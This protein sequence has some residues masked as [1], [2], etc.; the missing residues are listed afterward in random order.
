[1]IT[2]VLL[3]TT[4]SGFVPKFLMQDIGMLKERGYIVHYA[5]NFTNPIY[6]CDRAALEKQGILCHQIS[7]AKSPLAIRANL[8]ALRQLNRLVEQ[9]NI[10]VIYCNNPMG[11]VLGRLAHGKGRKPY[12]IYTAHGFHFY[13]GAPVKNWLIFYPV[14]RLLAHKT[15]QL[16]TINRED[17]NIADTF[18][19]RR[20]G[21]T[22]QIP[23]VG[24][25]T[26]RFRPAADKREEY[27]KK[28]GAGDEDYIF[29]AVG[30]LNDNKNHKTII[31]AFSQIED[32]RARLFICG[33]G[34]ERREL[35]LLIEELHLTDRVML[36]GYQTEIEAFY[37][38]ADCF[39]FPSVREGLG[40]A[41][42]EAM[43]CGLPIIVGANRGTREYAEE[44]A[45]VCEPKDVKAFAGAM[46][47]VMNN[48]GLAAD[49]GRRSIE[50]A[51]RFTKE[52]NAKVMKQVYERMGEALSETE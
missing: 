45:I 20:R 21:S 25:D 18:R 39:L 31:K 33:E 15:N 8:T 52:R 2:N 7:I 23:G 6:E 12:V 50:I 40:M 37:Q 28:Y 51:A 10:R 44:N 26:A 5:S 38:S 13:K 29:L 16:I 41:S 32:K 3:I 27:R 34:P 48:H 17:K 36:W 43:A 49:M 4:I 47:R 24:Y 19:L 11:G 46:N 22:V 35:L 9:E 42:I 30:E 14:E 1:M